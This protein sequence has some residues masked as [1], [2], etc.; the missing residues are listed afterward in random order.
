LSPSVPSSLPGFGL[1]LVGFAYFSVAGCAGAQLLRGAPSADKWAIAA[2]VPQVLQ[3]QTAG[4]VYK[5][6]CGLHAT[7]TVGPGVLKFGFG[8]LVGISLLIQRLSLPTRVGINLV[9][10][11]FLWYFYHQSRSRLT[12]A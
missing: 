11:L 5:V 3:I 4:L 12:S 8:A 10:A 2:L 9:P 6:V 1:L 7:I